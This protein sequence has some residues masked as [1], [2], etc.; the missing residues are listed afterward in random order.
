MVNFFELNFYVEYS[1]L[2]IRDVSK[3]GEISINGT[4]W[5]KIVL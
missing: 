2:I 5:L 1:Q 3:C 4:Y